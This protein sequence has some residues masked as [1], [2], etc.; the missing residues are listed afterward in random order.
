[1]NGVEHRNIRLFRTVE[2]RVKNLLYSK[3]RQITLCHL[4]TKMFHKVI[5]M[6]PITS[7][8]TNLKQVH[9]ADPTARDV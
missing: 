3:H 2:A 5:N 4:L 9:R 8:M 7:D 6:K 1:V